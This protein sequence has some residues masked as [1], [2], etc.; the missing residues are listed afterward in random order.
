MI[1]SH[2]RQQHTRYH[3]ARNYLIS[4]HDTL[5][6]LEKYLAAVVR[7]LLEES[8]PEIKRDYNEASFLYPFWANYPP[9]DRGRQPIKDQYPWIEVGE[10]AIGVK[11]ARLL[12][13]EFTLYDT[14]FPHGF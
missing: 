2:T 10:H 7:G 1:G 13:G 9:D 6:A 14:G 11:L 12:A 4:H 5:I 3:T 8:L